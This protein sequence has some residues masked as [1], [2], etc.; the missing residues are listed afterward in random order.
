M[1]SDP[2][3]LGQQGEAAA[4]AYLKTAGFTIIDTN[5][6]TKAAEVDIIAKDDP[7]ICFIEVKTRNSLKKGLPREAVTLPKQQKIIQAALLYCQKK[8]IH[9]PN[10]R[11]DVVEVIKKKDSLSVN[12]IKHAF[13]AG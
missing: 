13:Q 9:N 12:L 4:C 2:R 3:T 7:F 1:I 8:N 10:I 5:F 6:R 11:F